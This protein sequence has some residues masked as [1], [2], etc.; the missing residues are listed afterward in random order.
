MAEA[1]E[2]VYRSGAEKQASQIAHHLYQSGLA[3]DPEKTLRYLVLATDQAMA[4]SGFEEALGHIDAA[5]SMEEAP[6]GE[7]RADLL[8]KRGQVFR[9]LG[10]PAGARDAWNEALPIYE[11][12]GATEQVA[13]LCL[14]TAYAW[15]LEGDYQKAVDVCHRGLAAVGEGESPERCRLEAASGF[16]LG[17]IGEATH[18]YRVI[19][20]PKH[21]EMADDLLRRIEA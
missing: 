10:R 6:E 3:A 1:I 15:T 4:A 13:R 11:G 16:S 14:D 9:S 5:L 8:F 19:G 21:V 18:M 2:R 20:M 12:L 17:N 7:G